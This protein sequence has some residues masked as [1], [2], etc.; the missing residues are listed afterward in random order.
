MAK[1]KVVRREQ[2]D[3]AL[4]RFESVALGKAPGAGHRQYVRSVL[5]KALGETRPTCCSTAS[6]KAAMS[7]PS[8]LKWMDA[9]SVAEL[10]RNEH[11]QIIATILAH[12]DHDQSS[13]VLKLFSRRNRNEVLIRIATL[14]GISPRRSRTSTR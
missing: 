10:I 7:R 9:A 3:G 8:S 11:P 6:C 5:R 4:T 14:D 13:S 2:V 12:L 1:L